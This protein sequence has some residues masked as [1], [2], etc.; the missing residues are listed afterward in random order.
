MDQDSYNLFITIGRCHR[1]LKDHADKLASRSVVRAVKQ[2]SDM[3]NVDGAFRL[4]EYVDVELAD[5]QAMS[6]CLEVTLTQD[7][8]MVEADVRRIHDEGQDVLAT[9]ADCRYRN[10]VNCS[11][12]LGEITRELCASNPV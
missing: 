11:N 12:G 3:S 1:L 4:E 2:W 8:I 6:W 9:I 10:V 7:S 5:G